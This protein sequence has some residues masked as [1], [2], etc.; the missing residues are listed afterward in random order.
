MKIFLYEHYDYA[1]HG[2][3]R[4][5]ELLKSAAFCQDGGGESL[6]IAT[7]GRNA[8]FRL[9]SKRARVA[10]LDV[11][12]PLQAAVKLVYFVGRHRPN[13]ILCNNE[14]SLFTIAFA[15]VRWRVPIVWY[16]KNSRRCFWSDALA[17]F[18][19][20]RVLAISPESI[21]C[22][23][24]L[25][26]YFFGRKVYIQPIATELGK[27][28][29][30]AELGHEGE[31]LRILN[32]SFVGWDKGTDILVSALERLNTMGVCLTVRLAGITL[33]NSG[34]FARALVERTKRLEA[35]TVEWLGW[36]ENVVELL[37]W[38]D[39][40]VHP[41]RRDG[42]PRVLVEAMAAGRPVIAS[43]IGGIPT[44]V[45]HGETGFLIP[46]E[47]PKALAESL[48]LLYGN[49]EL[50]RSIG[51]RARAYACASFDIREHVRRLCVHL[52]EVAKTS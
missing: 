35:I 7:R 47:D 39:V 6:L 37:S 52:D 1:I 33:S 25:L 5:V 24:N 48:L 16:V 44:I 11:S 15:A 12:R 13:V 21:S 3:Q 27:F 29:S 46:P 8:L 28:A 50:C 32:L 10:T 18:L 2:N 23:D 30:I 51:R 40:V 19:C 22:K 4:Y 17:F 31:C 41:S 20:S 42:V 43:A 45:E 38:C 36:R 14:A 9:L 34:D 49:S 26:R